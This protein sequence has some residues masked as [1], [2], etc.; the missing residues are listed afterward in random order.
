MTLDRLAL[1]LQIWTYLNTYVR[2]FL[3]VTRSASAKSYILVSISIGVV[4]VGYSESDAP[5]SLS[6]A[7]TPGISP[8][9]NDHPIYTPISQH[10]LRQL[11]YIMSNHNRLLL[12]EGG[13]S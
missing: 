9:I 1:K 10:M 13:Y 3:S 12:V 4:M 6:I 11:R 5:T 8:Q 7:L 2:S